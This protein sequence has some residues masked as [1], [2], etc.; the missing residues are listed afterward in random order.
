MMTVVQVA[1]PFAQVS[2]DAAGGAEQVLA[3]IDEALVE[4]GHRSIVIASDGSRALG[5]LVPV[6]RVDAAID[7]ATMARIHAHVREALSAVLGRER[8]DVVH[9]HG[10]DFHAYLPVGSCP[11]LVTLHLDPSWY[12]RD[13]IVGAP[14]HVHLHAVSST[15][16]RRLPSCDAILPPIHNGVRL[17]RFV[18]R[19]RPREFVLALGRICREK[20]FELALDAAAEAAIPILVGGAVFPYPEHLRYFERTIL[21]R[22]G[23]RARFLG[24]LA[25]E[26]KRRLLAAARALVVTSVVDE[27][28]SLVAM[29]ALASGTPVVALSRGALPEIVDDGVTGILVDDPRDLA[30]ALRRV[31]RLDR[32][33]CRAAAEARFDVR[34]TTAA[35]LDTY[36]RLAGRG[37]HARLACDVREVA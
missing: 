6:P 14:P 37:T 21:P 34:G 18:P 22:L 16:A 11:T 19:G 28:S 7:G 25:L 35:Y 2:L 17:D 29:E 27:T 9:L 23:P 1:Y 33:R 15:Q 31:G 36:A 26:R 3:A 30:A 5:E 13:A 8:V 10:V 12:P 24:P 20:G 4:G 32:A